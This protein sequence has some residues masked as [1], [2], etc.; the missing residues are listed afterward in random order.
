MRWTDLTP[1]EWRDRDGQ[2]QAELEATG[3]F[4]FGEPFLAADHFKMA[5]NTAF[6]ECRH[7]QTSFNGGQQSDQTVAATHNPIVDLRSL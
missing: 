5:W 6:R 1:P 7:G 2:A 4:K 3:P